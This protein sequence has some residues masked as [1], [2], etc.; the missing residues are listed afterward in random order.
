MGAG[1]QVSNTRR[2][3]LLEAA[4]LVAVATHVA[5]PRY[6]FAADLAVSAAML[7]ASWL[8]AGFLPSLAISIALGAAVASIWEP[9]AASLVV[10]GWT[11]ALVRARTWLWILWPLTVVACIPQASR[12]ALPVWL[13]FA[14][15]EVFRRARPVEAHGRLAPWRHP[16]WWGRPLD[17][18]ANSR[19]F[20][21]LFEP[22]PEATMRSDITNVVYVNYLVEA[23]LA[24]RLVP[25]HLELQRLGPSGKYALFSFLTYQHGH[26]GFAF[27][28]PLRRFLPSP[29][30]TNWRIHVFDPYT[31]HRGIY[32][33][34]N[35]ITATAPALAARMTTEGMPMH[36]FSRASVRR[37]GGA[38]RITLE[39]GGGSAP[40]AEVVLA[41]SAVP[42]LSGAWA[43]CWPDFREFLAYC[44]PQDRAMSSQPLR[45]R[46]SRQEID[47]GIPLDVCVP[48]AGTV[49]SRAAAAI[50]GAAEPMCFLV[51]KVSFV[52]STEAHDAVGANQ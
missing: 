16:R 28:G 42:A 3:R 31:K 13:F 21:V 39:P 41:E 27:L 36:V 22:L 43:E 25:A 46:V 51:P 26:F 32:F 10:A 44:V 34:T 9:R 33:V 5:A 38:V 17:L 19:V 47:L 50:A 6:A 30:Q 52:F 49:K 4:L 40:D 24:E 18:I 1:E 29:I 8:A 12:L 15:E 7:A 14:A 11:V 37:E 20:Q 23:A 48:L 2:D 45:G 35:A